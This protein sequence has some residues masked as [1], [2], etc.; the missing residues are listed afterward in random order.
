MNKMAVIKALQVS[1]SEGINLIEHLR[2]KHSDKD[3]SIQNTI[4][5]LKTMLR[6]SEHVHDE[7]KHQL[8]DN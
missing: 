1:L 3:P 5:Q 6:Y 8:Y 4:E 7:P 2:E